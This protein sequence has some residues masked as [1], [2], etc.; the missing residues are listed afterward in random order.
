M[1]LAW[2]QRCHRNV[3][4]LIAF[5]EG[6]EK[7]ECTF[8]SSSCSFSVSIASLLSPTPFFFVS[9]SSSVAIYP[10]SHF[11]F[12]KDAPTLSIHFIFLQFSPPFLLFLACRS[13]PDVTRSSV[14]GG[15]R[16]K[17]F[18][19]GSQEVTDVTLCA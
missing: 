7:M 11:F 12:S 17:R 1:C 19:R 8:L 14:A 6:G 3:C 10:L 2:S 18:S 5:G 4:L 16:Q 9:L 13:S 15:R